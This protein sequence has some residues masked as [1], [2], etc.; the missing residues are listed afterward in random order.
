MVST[1]V[2]F[3]VVHEEAPGIQLQ[4][5]YELVHAR[6]SADP[7]VAYDY[8]DRRFSALE[9]E[10]Y[11]VDEAEYYFLL[12][13]KHDPNLPYVNHQL[14]RIEF[15]RGDFLDALI[16]I[17]RELEVNPDPSPSTYYI[18]GLI[19]GFAGL[20]DMSARDY[21]TYL[22]ADPTNWAAINDYAWVLLK[23][24]RSEEALLATVR[25]LSFFPE[26]PW[27]LNSNAIALYEEGFV[28]EAHEQALQA[29][30]HAMRLGERDWLIAYP[31]NDPRVAQEGLVALL[32][33]IRTN[34]L[35]IREA[36]AKGAENDASN[37]TPL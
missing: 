14:A 27:L 33:S 34:L 19:Q 28:D 15:L 9:P 7:H 17:N 12:A 35:V 26:N 37:G 25:G 6:L 11:D 4:K 1:L 10:W 30:K 24:D 2:A 22:Q 13:A 8:G 18:R 3:M 21:E 32:D 31:G 29:T 5:G 36:L 16:L 23:A 20:Y